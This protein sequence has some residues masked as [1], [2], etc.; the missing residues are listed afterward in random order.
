MRADLNEVLQAA[1]AL[2]A[3][4]RQE[5]LDKIATSLEAENDGPELTEAMENELAA[6]VADM[7]AGRRLNVETF[8]SRMR[9]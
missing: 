2:P 1:L 6:R 3:E 5:L 8:L 4:S 7:R 9:R